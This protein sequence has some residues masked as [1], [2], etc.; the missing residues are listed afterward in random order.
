V[1]E[2]AST[3]VQALRHL[4]RQLSGAP[5]Y[6]SARL[7]SLD[8]TRA[9][10]AEIQRTVAS[11][12]II[13]LNADD[14]VLWTYSPRDSRLACNDHADRLRVIPVAGSDSADA[15]ELISQW[16]RG[17]GDIY[18]TLAEASFGAGVRTRSSR[19][20]GVPL[21]RAGDTVIGFLL[22]MVPQSHDVPSARRGLEAFAA[23]VS[24][25]LANFHALAE[26]RRHEAELESLYATAEAISS[27]LDLEP[28]L[29]EI[30]ESARRLVGT[31]ISYIMLVDSSAN[32]IRMRTTAGTTSRSFEQIVLEL[33][34]GLGGMVLQQ[35]QP[36]QSHDY[37][38]DPEFTHRSD[39]DEEVRKEGIR[40]ILGVPMKSLDKFVGVLYVADRSVRDFGPADVELMTNL[41]RHAALAIENSMLYEQTSTMLTQLTLA[42]ELAESR[43]Q[44]L[45]RL[46]YLHR[47]LSEVVLAGQGVT[48]VVASLA[49]LVGRRVA[50]LDESGWLLAYSAAHDQADEF[51][52]QL[53]TK[54]LNSVAVDQDL[55]ATLTRI[56]RFDTSILAPKP[57]FRR[58]GRIVVPIVARAELVGSVWLEADEAESVTELRPMIEQAVRVLGLELLKER[59]VADA[60]RR[61]RRDFVEDLLG[62]GKASAVDVRRRAREINVDLEQPHRLAVLAVSAAA[63]RTGASD[64]RWIGKVIEALQAH[65]WCVFAGEGRGHA[66]ALLSHE[67]GALD[68]ALED[69]EKDLLRVRAV[70]SPLCTEPEDYAKYFETSD[71]LLQIVGSSAKE[72]VINL[73]EARVLALLFRS[74]GERELS[75]FATARLTPI[76][77][78]RAE[79]VRVLL[80][81]LEAYLDC[82]GSPKG[83]AERLHVHV[84]TVYYRVNRLRRL[85]GADFDSP[86]AALDLRI[87]LF[88]YRLTFVGGPQR[89]ERALEETAVANGDGPS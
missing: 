22:I 3:S 27:R 21:T 29:H 23:Q 31:P 17:E 33:G 83:A 10:L 60:E 67:A 6:L 62:A 47:N 11:E 75:E 28:V 84:N 14:A 30:V 52:R 19:S 66:I 49:D 87:A 44:Q 81:T 56:S 9:T 34:A 38:N 71:R 2:K 12:A 42:N 82:G 86:H 18:Y 32:W 35:E 15:S 8:L 54:G 7:S 50:V 70:V 25:L 36:F 41:A 26:V 37:L 80:G 1:T 24:A 59:S 85:L 89:P 57:P 43:Y 76:L 68:R 88:A 69:L 5:A 73:D 64:R 51:G 55:R 39:V 53:V 45:Q 13:V 65:H 20:I 48:G 58:Y 79:Q 46:D 74:G 77:S 78:Q 72:R 4:D 61:L 16:A 40:S 63:R